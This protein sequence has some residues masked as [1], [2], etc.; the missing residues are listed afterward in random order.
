MPMNH[1]G[2]ILKTRLYHWCLRI[3]AP[4]KTHRRTAQCKEGKATDN[5]KGTSKNS[6]NERSSAGHSVTTHTN[7][8]NIGHHTARNERKKATNKRRQQT[9][10]ST[11]EQNLQG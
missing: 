6:E 4:K 2:F 9:E 11:A 7:I 5:Q 8:A 1:L 10:P 3:G